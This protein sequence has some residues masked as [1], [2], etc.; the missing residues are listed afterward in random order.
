MKTKE[1]I[2]AYCF[3]DFLTVHVFLT[4]QGWPDFFKTLVKVYGIQ[5][6]WNFHA[7]FY[8]SKDTGFHIFIFLTVC[9][10]SIMIFEGNF[11]FLY[12]KN[13][14]MKSISVKSILFFLQMKTEMQPNPCIFF[15]A[16]VTN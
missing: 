13:H 15:T 4:V 3:Q 11:R 16:T 10:N 8:G 14:S 12:F 7:I 1:D 5:F 2:R 6:C 9:D